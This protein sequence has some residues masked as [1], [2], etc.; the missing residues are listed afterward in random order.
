VYNPYVT[1]GGNEWGGSIP[2]SDMYS[3]LST[4]KQAGNK[5]SSEIYTT[6][7]EETR[8][9]NGDGTYTPTSGYTPIPDNTQTD[10]FTDTDTTHQG[11]YLYDGV[12]TATDSK[13]DTVTTGSYTFG[14]DYDLDSL[15]SDPYV[16]LLGHNEL[17]TYEYIKQSD[18][19]AA[20]TG[21]RLYDSTD[22]ATTNYFVYDGSFI[23]STTTENNGSI[24]I[25]D[26]SN[27][28]YVNVN[29]INYYL[30]ASGSI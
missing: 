25:L 19:V 8:T 14:S 24:L 17:T 28:L 30:N 23:S 27:H 6:F 10:S 1:A 12:D 18:T 3:T 22:G 13:G 11:V 16:G 20:K 21:F 29:Q 4:K 26:D 5:Y 9:D 2:M 7:E 15:S